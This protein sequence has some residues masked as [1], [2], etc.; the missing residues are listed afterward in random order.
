MCINAKNVLN[1]L[2][3][4]EIITTFVSFLTLQRYN[5]TTLQRYNATTLQRYN[6]TTA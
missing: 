5:A 2:L 1:L 3:V 6:A 4:S